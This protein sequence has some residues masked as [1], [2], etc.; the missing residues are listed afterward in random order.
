[1]SSSQQLVIVWSEFA[2]AGAILLAVTKLF[3]VRLRHPVDRVNLIAMSLIAIAV[4]PLLFSLLSVPGFRLGLFSTD[5][6]HVVRTESTSRSPLA[7][8]LPETSD[9]SG[10]RTDLPTEVDASETVRPDALHRSASTPSP[11]STS[12]ADSISLDVPSALATGGAGGATNQRSRWSNIATIL[13]LSHGLAIVWFL[14][15]WI[16]GAARLRTISRTAQAPDQALLD[17]WMRVSN[18]LGGSARLLVTDKISAPMVFG[19]WRPVVLIPQSIATGN[20][21]ALRF[22]LAH[23]WSHV[24]SSDLPRWQ[25]TNLCQLL[26]WYQ[27]LFWLLRRELRIC[28]DLV[29][30]NL[31]VE[32]TSSQLDRIEYSELLMSIANQAMGPRLTGA[33]AFYDR[34]SQLSRRI[35]ILLDGQ[36]LRSRS[37]HSFY[38]MAGLLLLTGSLL[39]GSVRLS[40]VQAQESTP[41]EQATNPAGDASQPSKTV[42][43]IPNEA[44]PRIVRGRVVDESGEPV[45]G[46]KLWLRL[47]YQPSRIVPATT[48]DAGNFELTCLPE[49][50]SPR[51]SGSSWTVWAYAPGYSIQ[52]QSVF[53]VL[54]GKSEEEYTI[55]LPPESNTSFKILSPDGQPLA[56]V[57]V[58]PQNYKTSAGGYDLVPEEVQSAVSART[59]ENGMV[60]LPAIQSGPLFRVEMRSEEFGRQTI[61]VDNHQ[62]RADRSIR[63]RPIASIK[64]RIIGDD[65]EW[66]RDVKLTFATDNRGQG[67]EPQGVAEVVTNDE[68]NFQVPIIASGGPLRTYVILDPTLPV[69]PVLSE[70]VF[71]SAG[72]TVELDIPLVA[73]PLVQGKVV[74]KSTGKPVANAE[75]SLGYGGYHQSEQVTTD[76]NGEY[77]GRILPGGVRVHIISLP[78]GFVQLG[79]PWAKPY[80]VPDN[81]D[82]FALP[83]IEVV[84]SHEITGQ[85]VGANN[86]P[87]PNVQIMAIDENRRYGH[88]ESDTEGRFKM[89]V[90]D[91]IETKVEVYL[92]DRGSVPVEV[93]QQ[94]PLVVRYTADVRE[95][96]IEAERAKKPDVTLIGRVL[97]S[98]EPVAGVQVILNRGVPISLGSEERTGT[99]YSQVSET[100]TDENGKYRVTGLKSGDG[101]Q[102][103]LKPP[104]PAADPTWHHQPPYIQNLAED[105]KGEVELPDVDLLKLSQSIAG[106]VVDP[107]GEPV[108]GAQVTVQLRSGEHLARLTQSGPPPWTESDHQGRFHLKELPDEPLSI[109]AFF[110]NPKGGR[111]RF[112]AKLDVVRNQQDIHIVLDPSLREVEEE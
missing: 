27:P 44:Q 12:S 9:A 32:A 75:I 33:M 108:K 105:A 56:G 59:D 80:Q 111:I 93:I 67:T 18:N 11:A 112:P 70:N 73:A 15:Q 43:P 52:T 110:A 69:R 63:L 30:D 39:V 82:E 51:V 87:L 29:A 106:V 46:A 31:A 65:P 77:E 92:E 42:E 13:L 17:V 16:I 109:M 41:S 103:E 21:S 94:D 38:W 83:T 23:E 74:A 104:Y 85:L 3:V 10:L 50:I 25:L 107:D 90:P 64:G 6:E 58:Q 20:P 47:H 66:I 5:G 40:T 48:D 78:D 101:Y 26:F 2:V 95:K 71:L 4:V 34:S 81:V 55:Q 22:C 53:E 84:T 97:M 54:R 49:W 79:A 8:Q 72:E 57:L 76:E 35:K 102:I 60:T 98:G 7:I 100:E 1:M 89:R 68:G 96:E 61:R 36:S 99:R 86:Q 24:T 14:L 37:T 88:G 62:D 91:G 19:C 45:A 28:Q